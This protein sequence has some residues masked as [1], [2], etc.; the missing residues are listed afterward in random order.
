MT[1]PLFKNITRFKEVSCNTTDRN[2]KYLY[3]T[4]SR[5]VPIGILL[6]EMN[7]YSGEIAIAEKWMPEWTYK[8]LV[9]LDEQNKKK[10]EGKKKKKYIDEKWHQYWEKQ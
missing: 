3:T 9:G 4:V 6:T 2:E 5:L 7:K 8:F 10:N 1:R